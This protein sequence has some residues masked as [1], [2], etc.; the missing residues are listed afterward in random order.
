MSKNNLKQRRKHQAFL[1]KRE[2]DLKK[3][4][5]EKRKKTQSSRKPKKFRRS[6]RAIARAEGWFFG[7]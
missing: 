2:A 3:K 6:L 7:R 5:D 1:L 4:R